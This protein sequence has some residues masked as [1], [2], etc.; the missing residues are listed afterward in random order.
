[1]GVVEASQSF[2]GKHPPRGY[3]TNSAARRSLLES[4]T[5]PVLVIIADTIG[6]QP[7]QLVVIQSDYVIQQLPAAALASIWVSFLNTSLYV[8]HF[9]PLLFLAR[10]KKNVTRFSERFLP[11]TRND[12]ELPDD[13][14][15]VKGAEA[16]SLPSLRSCSNVLSCIH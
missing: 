12:Y 15:D 1:V 9:Y 5:S 7:A 3:R 6:K 10:Q 8:I 4:E 16:R 14:R 13:A 11:R 2:L